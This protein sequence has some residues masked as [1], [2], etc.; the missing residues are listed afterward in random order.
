MAP[1][2]YN[3]DPRPGLRLVA[4]V[5]KTPTRSAPPGN[6]DDHPASAAPRTPPGGN[7]SRGTD[8]TPTL[9]NT[10]PRPGFRRGVGV[11]KTPTK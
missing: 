6:D 1:C 8:P 3:A 2:R 10:D 4:G 7:R 11:V 9:D 5:V